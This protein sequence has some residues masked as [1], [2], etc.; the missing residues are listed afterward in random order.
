MIVRT[1]TPN[2]LSQLHASN[3]FMQ[4]CDPSLHTGRCAADLTFGLHTARPFS[5]APMLHAR[6]LS[7]QTLRA[8]LRYH[9]SEGTVRIRSVRK[10]LHVYALHQA[11][12]AH[13]ST[14]RYRIRDAETLALRVGDARTLRRVADAIYR[15]VDACPG[16]SPKTAE[17][18]I[19]LQVPRV[20]SV[21][22][23]AALKLL[24]ER[25]ELVVTNAA[26][27]WDVESR[28]IYTSSSL[29]FDDGLN[30]LE[31]ADAEALLFSEYLL[32]YSPS[33]IGDMAWW[34]GLSCGR[35]KRALDRISGLDEVL[36]EGT[37]IS[38]FSISRRSLSSHQGPS[39]VRFLAHEDPLL[40]AYYETR[41][42]FVSE[43][44][45]GLIFNRI[46][47]V[48]PA[49]VLDGRV[50]GRWSTSRVRSDLAWELFA[51]Q[52]PSVLASVV[53]EAGRMSCALFG[54]LPQQLPG[55]E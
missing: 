4:L 30:S 9:P 53:A 47:E 55:L 5:L 51:P 22:F 38:L 44:Q 25:G 12:I 52:D 8:S 27:K 45:Y 32:R 20:T 10:T 1:I 18:G 15:W 43:D 26:K 19:L 48:R 29:G 11:A 6:G 21:Q 36:L 42:R 46:G 34:S 2:E 40:K 39:V 37:G 3:A 35:V 33:S 23:R 16:N 24:W 14:K 28:E 7:G 17:A 41:L 49:I 13:C 54:D 50:I 31:E